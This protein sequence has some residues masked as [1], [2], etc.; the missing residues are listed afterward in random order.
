MLYCHCIMKVEV[1]F[2]KHDL[3]LIFTFCNFLSCLQMW[4]IHKDVYSI[5]GISSYYSKS[6]CN[7]HK[8]QLW[9]PIVTLDFTVFN[10]GCAIINL[11]NLTSEYLVCIIKI[12]LQQLSTHSTY[13]RIWNVNI[14]V[15]NVGYV[16]VNIFCK[17][18]VNVH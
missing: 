17:I 9:F 4:F 14:I 16:Q 10:V 8:C 6:Y 2:Q 3:M 15:K 18:Q 7:C 5:L 12:Y 13:K 11:V 1:I